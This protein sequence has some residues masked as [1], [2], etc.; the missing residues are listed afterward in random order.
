MVPSLLL[1]HIIPSQAAREAIYSLRDA[2]ANS[3]GN[4]FKRRRKKYVLLSPSILS[5]SPVDTVATCTIGVGELSRGL[6]SATSSTSESSHASQPTFAE[7]LCGRPSGHKVRPILQFHGVPASRG[8]CITLSDAPAREQ[9]QPD[10]KTC[11]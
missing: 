10:T 7:L 9:L 5:L 2:S 4:S 1:C 8:C 3:G 11:V 6:S